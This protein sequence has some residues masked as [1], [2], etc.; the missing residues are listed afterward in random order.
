M[1]LNMT[2]PE[3][4]NLAEQSRFDEIANNKEFYLNFTAM[5]NIEFYFSIIKERMEKIYF[6]VLEN[7]IIALSDCANKH[8]QKRIRNDYFIKH[9]LAIYNLTRTRRLNKYE[10]RKLIDPLLMNRQD[11][12]MPF[13]VH[14]PLEIKTVKDLKKW[15]DNLNAAINL[16]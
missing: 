10:Q 5:S 15:Q 8:Y 16:Y 9:F 12:M 3:L 6:S 1:N 2:Y 7:M 14:I 4:L 11:I 13:G